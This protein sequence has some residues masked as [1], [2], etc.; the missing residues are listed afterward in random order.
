[1][2]GDKEKALSVAVK[3]LQSGL[4]CTLEEVKEGLRSSK[5]AGRARR[6]FVRYLLDVGFSSVEIAEIIEATPEQ[7]YNCTTTRK[8]DERTDGYKLV[9]SLFEASIRRQRQAES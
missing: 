3:A 4:G 9:I 1:M 6:I 2:V 5:R 8:K 7:V